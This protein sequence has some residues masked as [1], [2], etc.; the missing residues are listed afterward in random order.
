MKNLAVNLRAIYS[1]EFPW[2]VQWVRST[3]INNWETT[4]FQTFEIHELIKLFSTF[5]GKRY[6]I[7]ILFQLVNKQIQY[8]MVF[9]YCTST[10]IYVFYL[11]LTLVFE[12]YFSSH[13]FFFVHQYHTDTTNNFPDFPVHNFLF[14][15]VINLN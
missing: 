11:I 15:S 13:H 7:F 4:R 5:P 2:L 10:M 8:L 6:F 12:Y 3:L 14:R 1:L 9:I